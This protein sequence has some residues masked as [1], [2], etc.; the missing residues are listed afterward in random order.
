LIVPTKLTAWYDDNVRAQSAAWLAVLFLI[1]M[2]C[3]G[4]LVKS[5]PQPKYLTNFYLCISAGGAV[6]GL[7]VALIA[8]LVFKLHFEL[9]L[10]IICGFVVGWVALANDGRL[11]WLKGREILQWSAAFFI[12]GG[13]LLI[14]KGN[15][16]G[17]EDDVVAI[18]RNFYGTVKVQKLVD[19]EDPSGSGLALYNGRIW[20]GFQYSDPARAMEP[21]TYYVNNTGAALSVHRHP[22]HDQPMRVAVIGLG[23]GTMAVHGKKGDVFRFYDID[24]KVVKVANTHFTYLRDSDA[25]TEVILGD[26]RISLEREQDQQY[27]VIVLDAFSG[28][29]IPAHLLTDEAFATYHRHLR[30][31]GGVPMGVV[32]IHI[33]NRYLDLEPVVA[34]IAKKHGYETRL[35][36]TDEGFAASDTGSDW[37]LVSQNLEFLNDAV[38]EKLGKPLEPKHE[39][40]WTDQRTSLWSILQT[41][42]ED[43][44]KPWWKFW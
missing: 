26:A 7:F 37:V 23:T 27:D 20:H 18:E 16:E 32:A 25:Q 22:R 6:G 17:V 5:K 13:V 38:V 10:S 35:V 19:D 36:H 12:V 15:I 4:E 9:A 29:A 31:D 30:R 14:A 41:D 44:T 11:S 34:A 21:S 3:H 1:C 24:P 28:D 2:V 8:P 39:L 43:D 40:L 33:S 42:D